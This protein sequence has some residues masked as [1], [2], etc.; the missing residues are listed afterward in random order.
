[1]YHAC[2]V[3]TKVTTRVLYYSLGIAAI[4][5]LLAMILPDAGEVIWRLVGTSIATAIA[6]AILLVSIKRQEN[7]R[8]RIF[9]IGVGCLALTVYFCALLSI[10]SNLLL[11]NGSQL[12]EKF[13]L[14]A[15]LFAGCG[16]LVITGLFF[17]GNKRLQI[18]GYALSILWTIPLIGWLLTIWVF[19]RNTNAEFAAK[20][21]LPIQTLFPLVVA[22]CIRRHPYYMIVAIGFAITCCI[23]TQIGMYTTDLHLERNIPLLNVILVCGGISAI[24]GISNIIFYR[25]KEFS[26]AWLEYVTLLLIGVAVFVLC[27][28]IWYDMQHFELPELYLRLSVG[29]SIL[30]STSLIGLLVGQYVRASGFSSY[31]GKSI[32]GICPRCHTSLHIPSGKSFCEA[33]GL[34]MKLQVESPCCRSCGYDVSKLDSLNSCPECGEQIILQK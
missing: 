26:I 34:Q 30:G 8:T 11:P 28:N 16:A 10:W 32:E 21:L 2:M 29:S 19:T 3:T 13:G 31:D 23:T 5:G 7:P 22:A 4:A 24:L 9:G 12:E 17:T 25:K 14:S 27:I 1:M 15:L 18:A 6:S 33:C 20:L